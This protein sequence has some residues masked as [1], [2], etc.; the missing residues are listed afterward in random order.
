MGLTCSCSDDYGPGDKLWMEPKGYAPLTTKRS[1]KCCSCKA[2]I[3][4]GALCA[5]VPR[6][7]IPETD[8][9]IRIYGE[10]E[11]PIASA[12][13]CERCADLCFSFIDLGYCAKPWEDQRELLADY[14]DMH[15]PAETPN[16]TLFGP[17]KVEESGDE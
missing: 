4:I 6:V 17:D 16:N 12:W 14:V 11:K 9:E 3:E 5:E 1:K 7:K 2:R 10:E 13:M 15:A 8:I